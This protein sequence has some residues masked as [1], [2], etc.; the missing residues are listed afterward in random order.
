MIIK[1]YLLIS[2]YWYE[3]K[4]QTAEQ[5]IFDY[6]KTGIIEIKYEAIIQ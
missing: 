1:Q 5:R 2:N 3:S 4:D 6:N